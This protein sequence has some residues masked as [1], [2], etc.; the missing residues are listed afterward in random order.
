MAQEIPNVLYFKIEVAGTAAK[1][2]DCI[3]L[4]GDVIEGP[5]DGEEA[6]TLMADL[7]AGATGA[8]TGG[9]Y[10]DG[11]HQIIDP[12]FAGKP[13]E[14]S[15]AYERWLPLINYENRQ[16]GLLATKVLMK[17]GGVIRSEA[18]RHPLQPCIRGPGKAL[19]KLPHGLIL[20]CSAGDGR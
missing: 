1:L 6:I 12:Y 14:A 2:R 3:A 4:R 7:N 11:I 16:C 15:A 20:P 5:S 9:A 8:M 13:E 10:S 18:V 17:E 19:S